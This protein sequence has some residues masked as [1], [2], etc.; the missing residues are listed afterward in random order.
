MESTTESSNR[1]ILLFVLGVILY[2]L[3]RYQQY[4][5]IYNSPISVEIPASTSLP[6]LLTTTKSPEIMNS[7]KTLELLDQESTISKTNN[8]E[9]SYQQDSMVNSQDSFCEDTISFNSMMGDQ[10]STIS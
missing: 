7:K 1:L 4:V 8:D 5:N 3:Y 2:L 6:T 10:F 9:V